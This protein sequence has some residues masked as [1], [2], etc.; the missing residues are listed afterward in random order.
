MLSNKKVNSELS[1]YDIN[2]L[3]NKKMEIIEFVRNKLILIQNI[4][5]DLNLLTN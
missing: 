3:F 5:K 4:I 2:V 1:L